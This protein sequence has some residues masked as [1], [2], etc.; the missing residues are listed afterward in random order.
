ME[1]LDLVKILKNCPKGTTLYST[2]HGNVELEG[3]DTSDEYTIKTYVTC[4]GKRTPAWFTS[5]GRYF[6]Y[7]RDGDCVLFPSKECR[8]WSKFKLSQ[9][10]FRKGDYVICDDLLGRVV[11]YHGDIQ[12][13]VNM[14]NGSIAN[15][16]FYVKDLTKV[17]KFDPKWFKTGDAVLV[18]DTCMED[19][20]YTRFSHIS[21]VSEEQPFN[22]SGVLWKYCIPYNCETKHLV[23]TTANEPKFYR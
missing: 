23:G 18:R 21:D 13:N 2:I 15:L 16:D 1:K 3:I 22:A 6:K 8:D 11:K 9:Q 19:W 12:C 17:E 14:L 5:D 7:Y 20:C 10:K 4:N